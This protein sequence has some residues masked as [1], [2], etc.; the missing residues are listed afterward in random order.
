MTNRIPITDYMQAPYASVYLYQHSGQY[1]DAH[2]YGI[3]VE[4]IPSDSFSP[5]A[6]NV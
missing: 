4:I 6:T 2:I 5:E 1:V 3:G